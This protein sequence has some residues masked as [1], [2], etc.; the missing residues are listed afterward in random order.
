[1]GG[2]EFS[3]ELGRQDLA[4]PPLVARR[5]DRR[6]AVDR[7]RSACW[8]RN[9]CL[10]SLELFDADTGL[11]ILAPRPSPSMEHHMKARYAILLPLI[12]SSCASIFSGGR[13]TITINSIEP[14]TKIFVDGAFQGE[15]SVS[16][17]VKRGKKHVIRVEKEG[18]QTVSEQT[19]EALDGSM[20]LGI[21]ID[22]GIITIPVDLIS[23][24]AWK[25]E[26]TEYTVTPLPIRKPRSNQLMAKETVVTEAHAVPAIP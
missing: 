11:F 20:F 21:L 26:P 22:W 19:G 5:V 18:C 6:G 7:C 1:M 2:R 10:S 9:G 16:V 13:D 12:F 15:N 14:G 3:R 24:S 4:E 23:G 17:D 25:T 8:T